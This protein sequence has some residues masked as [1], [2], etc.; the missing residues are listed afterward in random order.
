[1]SA[2]YGVDGT[3]KDGVFFTS[4]TIPKVVSS[5][6]PI[7][8]R[9]SG[10]NRGPGAVKSKMAKIA[11]KCGAN[12]I[13]QY[14]CDQKSHKWWEQVFTFRWDSESWHGEGVAVKAQE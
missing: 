1:M 14:S 11:R 5:L 12:A 13:M 4:G 7:R 9:V 8:V 2:K 10:Q 3:E 6:G